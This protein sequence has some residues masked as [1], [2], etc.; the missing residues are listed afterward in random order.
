[1]SISYQEKDRIFTLQT[2]RTTYIIGVTPEGYVGHIYYGTRLNGHVGSYPLRTGEPPFTP[3]VLPGEKC[4]FL[5]EFPMEYPAGGTGDF[6]ESAL[7]VLNEKGQRAAELL[8]DS[9]VIEDGKPALEGLPA[10]F[11]GGDERVK[12]LRLILKDAVLS[13]QV[14]LLYSVFEKEDVITRSVLVTNNSSD[15][16][17]LDK[18]Y[19]ACLDMD[20]HDFEFLT[21]TGGWGRE[22]HI[23]TNRI[24]HGRVSVGSLQGKSSHQEHPFIALLTPGADQKHGEVYGM[25]FVYSGNFKAQAELSQWDMIRMTMGIHPDEFSWQLQP[26]QTFTAP[27]CVMSFSSEGLGRFSRNLHDF[28][29]N[30]MIRS[31]YLHE[32][33]PILIN[34]WEATYFDFDTEKLLSIARE[35]KKAGIEMLVMDDGW[36]GHRDRDN[37]SLGDWFVYEKKL[38]GGLRYLVE[39]VKKIGLK[40]GIWFEPEM[41]S[42]DSELY[43]AHPDWALQVY[44]REPSQSRMQYVLDYSRKDVRDYIYDM[45]ASILHEAPIDY[46]KWDM[47]RSLS[48]I[49]SASLPAGGQREIFHRYVLGLYELQER[50]IT[51]FPDLLLENCSG[52]GARFD[53][54]ML[55]YSPQIWCSDDMDSVE[56]L[57]IQEGTALIYPLSTMGAHVCCAPNHTTG[58]TLPFATRGHVA[59]AGTFGYELDIT[60]I[61]QEDRDMIPQQ[62]EMYHKYH[63]LVAEGDYY[64]IHS[65]NDAKPYDMWGVVSKDRTEAL[66]TH[67]QVLVTPVYRSCMICLDGLDPAKSYS[68]KEE[69]GINEARDMG[70]FTGEELMLVGLQVAP[71]RGD[72]RSRLYSLK[73]V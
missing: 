42:P 58:R 61:P 25:H 50:L 24:M 67:V 22:R 64:R 15:I 12:T 16:R 48:D 23:E 47:N 63:M 52:G 62:V 9:Y 7:E 72:Y 8:Y 1:M 29:R 45:V 27:E 43:K 32:D 2:E 17:T 46:V 69:D 70:V 56:R 11:A 40:F 35:A 44:K 13:L 26:G 37:S 20:N 3:G 73:E 49:G 31:K 19:S 14:T 54:G 53:P 38:T 5:G 18:V 34:N 60:A 6:R 57:R 10:A 30:H 68:V 59:L 41:I 55:Y 21:L 66:F 33:R 51:E 65:W 71:A 28:Y 4:N 36:F 39:E